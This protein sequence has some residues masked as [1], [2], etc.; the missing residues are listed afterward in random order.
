M[1][2][3]NCINGREWCTHAHCKEINKPDPEKGC[4]GQAKDRQW[5]MFHVQKDNNL[6]SR[7]SSLL[8]DVLSLKGRERIEAFYNEILHSVGAPT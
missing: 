4:S 2:K 7:H 8:S 5:V 3:S 1:S 6:K